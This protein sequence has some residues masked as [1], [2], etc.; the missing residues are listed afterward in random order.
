MSTRGRRCGLALLAAA[1]TAG[2]VGHAQNSPPVDRFAP[3]RALLGSWEGTSEGQPGNGTV[4]RSYALAL[5]DRFVEVQNT[6]TYPPQAKNPKGETHEDRGFFGYDDARKRLVFRQFHV[7]GFV[8]EYVQDETT[9]PKRISFSSV[10]IENIP[11]GWTARETYVMP[12]P[13]ELE[14]IFELAE[15]GK[16]LELYSRSRLKRIR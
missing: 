5:R 11:P 13:D 7:E 4:R 14:E 10:G 1:L 12:G 8:V 15:P 9:D 16:P 2:T 6:S 3:L